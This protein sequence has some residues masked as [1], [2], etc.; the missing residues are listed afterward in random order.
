[1]AVAYVSRAI[2]KALESADE[3]LCKRVDKARKQKK[4]PDYYTRTL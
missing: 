4:I 1:M 3:W 2:N